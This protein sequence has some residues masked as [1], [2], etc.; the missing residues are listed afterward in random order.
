[1]FQIP[2]LGPQTI[3]PLS[4]LPPITVPVSIDG[5]TQPGFVAGQPLIE[6]NGTSAG[7]NSGL[8]LLAGSSTVRGLAI[9]RFNGSAIDV[10]GPGGNLVAGNFIG[11]DV[12]GTLNR[13]NG[14]EGVWINGS[15]GNVVGGTNAADRNVLS[16]NGDAGVYLLNTASNTV[17]GN[18]IG[19]T[20]SGTV[21]LGNANDGVVVYNSISNVI[22]S[23]A[24]GARN[25][26]SANAASGI[27]LVGSSGNAVK[28]NLIGTDATGSLS[29]SN[30]ADGITLA[31]AASNSLGGAAA[32]EGNVI[33]GNG[34]AGIF[35]N[36]AGVVGNL[37]QGN[38]IGTDA[39]GKVAMGNGFAGVELLGA[40]NNTVGGLTSLAWNVIS[41]NKQNGIYVTNSSGNTVEGNFIGVDS[42]GAK[43]LAN[44]FNGITIVGAPS[45]VIGGTVVSARNII[46]G[47]GNYGVQILNAGANGNFV[48]QNFIGCDVIGSN[49]VANQFSGIRIEC[50]ANVIGGADA[51]NLISGNGQD[52]ITLVGTSAWA[53]VIQGNLIGTASNGTS[54]L[55][56]GRAGIGFSDAPG[57]TIGGTATGAGNVLSANLDAG[58]YLIGSGATGNL[59]QG[60]IIGAD[61]TGTV[62]LGN[63]YEGL[64]IERAPTNNIGGAVPGAGNLISANHTRGIWLT[65]A[66]WNSVQGNLIGTKADGV[67]A[68]G[69]TFHNVECEVGAN[70]NMIGGPGGAG[71]RI[72]FAQ[73]AGPNP[74]AGVRIRTGSINNAI[75][76]N[77]IFSNAALG[78]DLG[79]FGV[80]GNISCNTS[81]GANM[82]QNYPVLTQAVSGQTTVVSGT[83]N[84]RAS[85]TFLLQF[86]ASQTC[87]PTGNG[88]GQIYLGDKT[89]A[90][91][92]SCTTSFNATLPVRVPAGYVITST[93]T[94]S[95]NNTSEFSACL[96]VVLVPNL[97]LTVATNGNVNLSWTNNGTT[98]LL[99]QTQNLMP[100]VQWITVTNSPVLS[101]GQFVVSLAPTGTNRF[102]LL[103]YE[104]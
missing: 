2:G 66:S 70:N 77:A 62:A 67:S 101:N 57:N 14:Q 37:V 89:V 47:N 94:D 16:A 98:F 46:S 92:G 6:I 68:L 64:Y 29:M 78:I 95:A 30:A 86:F 17:I 31:G 4:A 72:A 104:Y 49:A 91:G 83:F 75:L 43:A 23:N 18:F 36:G 40:T 85:S 69:N 100:P 73:T 76:G 13:G 32:G 24:N 88:E 103:S 55:S 11:T 42:T 52:G 5:T 38:L 81:S 41:G 63:T 34:Q 48:Q 71:N 27:Y 21:K 12:T 44:L 99:K 20:A 96:P 39:S 60:N 90:T 93:A 80:N 58:I 84:S 19:T 8:R 33:S 82:L 65:N 28:G 35:L 1:M 87:D 61:I 45:N 26:I 7:N 50:S 15:P 59:I 56:N 25:V 51:G 10:E 9:N 97:A 53:N 102:F 54:G 22:G 79:T 3:T 74:Y